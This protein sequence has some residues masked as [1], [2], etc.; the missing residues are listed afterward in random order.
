MK[1][2]QIYDARLDVCLQPLAPTLDEC[3]WWIGGAG[4]SPRLGVGVLSSADEA[5]AYDRWRQ[6]YSRFVESHPV[7]L[8]G[9]PGFFSRFGGDI[10]GDWKVYCASDAIEVPLASFAAIQSYET[11][12]FG[13]FPKAPADVVLIAR[14]IDDA[15]W[16]FFFRED[17]MHDTLLGRLKSGLLTKAPW[18]NFDD[19]QQFLA[20]Q[21]ELER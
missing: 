5:E 4:A 8:I 2:I 3:W 6:E 1:V 12:W 17:W 15:Y 14:N 21:R 9:R 19:E 16:D 10:D 7:G 20:C 11:N 13:D 18:K